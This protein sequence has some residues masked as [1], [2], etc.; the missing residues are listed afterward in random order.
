MDKLMSISTVL[1]ENTPFLQFNFALPLPQH[2]LFP[3]T[4]AQQRR[5]ALLKGDRKQ[6]RKTRPVCCTRLT[7]FTTLP[8]HRHTRTHT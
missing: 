6:K 8:R 5:K 4:R 7:Q 3:P 1:K 2:L